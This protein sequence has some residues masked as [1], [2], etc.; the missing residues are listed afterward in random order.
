LNALFKLTSKVG[1]IYRLAHVTLL[2]TVGGG[3]VQ[4]AEGMLVVS[5]LMAAEGLVVPMVKIEGIAHSILLELGEGWL[6][7][8]RIDLETWNTICD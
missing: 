1:S 8:N 3:T 2:Q 5:L 4:V 7:N 6:V